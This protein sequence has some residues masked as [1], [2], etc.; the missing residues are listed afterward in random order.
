[1]M[2]TP[3]HV[4][5]HLTNRG[6]SLPELLIV[7]VL[8]IV[9]IMISTSAF[10]SILTNSSQQV[11]SSESNIQGVVGLEIMRSDLES[12][13][14]GLPWCQ[15]FVADWTESLVAA[16]FLANGIDPASFN[17]TNN[18]TKN[19]IYSQT[20]N[21]SKGYL[22]G[23]RA[24]QSGTAAGANAWENGRDY[25][26]IKSAILGMNRAAK[27]WS[28]L[29]YPGGTSPEFKTWGGSDD[30]V[31]ADAD[32]HP[33]RVITLDADDHRLI[34]TSTTSAN[35]SY[36]FTAANTPS[37]LFSPNSSDL[38]YLVYGV[39]SAS[40]L[41]FP[42]NRVDYYIK[43]PAATSD[44]PD[45][46]ASGT[47]ILYKANLNHSGGGVTQ[48]PLLECVADMQVVYALDTTALDITPVGGV[49]LNCDQNCLS[50]YTAE[51]IRKMLKEIKVYVLTHEGQ[52]DNSYTYPTST[53]QVGDSGPGRAYDLTQ[54]SGIGADWKHYR[55]K[56]YT[57][58]V[59]PKNL[60]N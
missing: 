27:K 14:Y 45:R 59:K 56:V 23:P 21:S 2:A 10:N 22:Q 60:N 50:A 35:F 43:R 46:C 52:K 37:A 29:Y 33:D 30:F 9:V 58:V 17:D 42:Y 54:L 44:M 38:N 6:F 51:Q 28:Y 31:A 7:M 55:W 48:Y 3:R 36:S 1:M 13:G 5:L 24:I 12:T 49:N 4:Q 32:G 41:G 34:G 53:V 15:S 57:I 39:N 8:F 20:S 11:K 18:P 47:G 16:N 19:E 26:V 25:L 40:A